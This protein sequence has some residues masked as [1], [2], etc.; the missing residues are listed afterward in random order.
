MTIKN[1]GFIYV[2]NDRWRVSPAFDINPSPSRHDKSETGIVTGGVFDASLTIALNACEFFE[3][4]LP[5]ARLE[6]CRIA[7]VTAD[8][9]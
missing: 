3:L 5:D 7:N 8:N 1:H 6:A 2:G 9:W 4:N